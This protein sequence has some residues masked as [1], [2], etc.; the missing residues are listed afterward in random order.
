MLV[1]LIQVFDRG[2][3]KWSWARKE[4]AIAPNLLMTKNT[5]TAGN[6]LGGVGQVHVIMNPRTLLMY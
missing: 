2:L 4:V 5:N 3:R 6:L 1:L